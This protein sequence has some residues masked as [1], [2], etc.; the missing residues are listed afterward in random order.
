MF[1]SFWRIFAQYTIPWSRQA[2]RQPRRSR[3]HCEWLELRSLPTAFVFSTGLPDGRM[4]TIS[5][6]PNAHNSQVEFESADDFILANDT[7][8][9]HAAFTGLLTGGATL[10][11]VSNVFIT[12]YRVFPK[13]SDVSRTSG[14]LTFSTK[15]VPTRVNS[16][17]DDEI[18]NRDSAAKELN[19]RADVLAKAFAAQASVSSA[20]KIAVK[21]GGNGRATGEE[22]EFH[23]TFRNH[24]LDLRAGQ[25]FFVPKVG[26][27][28]H[29]PAA[30][31]FL[32]L[33]APK[34]IVPPGTPFMP[35]LQ[36]WMRDDPGLAPDWLRIGTD[37]IGGTTFNGTF[38]LSGHS[39]GSDGSKRILDSAA[40]GG[41]D[42]ILAT[43][44]NFTHQEVLVTA[45]R[46][47]ERTKALL[48]TDNF[49]MT[50]TALDNTAALEN[51]PLSQKSAPPLGRSMVET[52]L[53]DEGPDM[54]ASEFFKGSKDR[55]EWA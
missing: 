20:N 15:Q 44:S 9:T 25:Y 6:P 35:D 21:S 43:G 24:P 27:T 4:A 48:P 54:A 37:I 12:I 19:F 16:P 14:L 13:D 31:D 42:L 51:A 8:I 2:A 1:G 38:S 53:G 34:P 39:S 26:L 49:S 52:V 46:G 29:A 50:S 55:R 47:P 40:G 22:V 5:E 30:A 36:S 33:S 10:A 23:I 7:V 3:L 41:F 28:D 32:W 18:E 45:P 17:A 11:D